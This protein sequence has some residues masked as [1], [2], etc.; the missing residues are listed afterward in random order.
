M[1]TKL[2]ELQPHL[3]ARDDTL[4]LPASLAC[5][6]THRHLFLMFASPCF[7]RRPSALLSLVHRPTA[8]LP[9]LRPK[10]P[11]RTET[12]HFQKGLCHEV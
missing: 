10:P 8:A 7:R 5:S 11:E 9:Y 1:K 2:K 4:Y 12:G 6:C 3:R